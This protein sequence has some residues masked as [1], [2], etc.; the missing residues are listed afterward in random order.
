M[1]K[2]GAAPKQVQRRLGHAKPS[3]TLN[4]YT[5]LWEAEEDRTAGMMEATLNDVP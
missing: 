3:I 1:T 5:H 2:N 4:V